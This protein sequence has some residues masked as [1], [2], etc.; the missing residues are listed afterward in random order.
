MDL[1]AIAQL[2][3]AVLHDHLDGGLRPSTIL[4]LADEQGYSGLPEVDESS[5]TA[6]FYQG[7]SGSLETYLEAFEQ[8]V[9]VMQTEAAI[10]RVAYEAGIDLDSQGVVYAEVRYGPMLSTRRGLSLDAVFEAMIDGF[11]RAHRDTGIIV[12]GIATALRHLADSAK[13]AIAAARYVDRGIVAFDLAGP[14]AG[15][16]PDAH[17][18]A[19]RIAR[20]AGL[21]LTLHAGEADGAHSMWRALALCGAQRLGHGVRIVDDAKF[22]NGAL[23]DLGAF[24]QRVRDHQV[25]LEVAVTSNLQ[26]GPWALPT[27]HPFGAMFGAGFNVSINTDNRLMSGTTMNDEYA[28]VAE[29][30][31][32]S[33]A[34]L[35][36]ITVNALRAGFG[37]WPERRRLI[38]RI[39]P[40]RDG[41]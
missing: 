20:D 28:L 23:T 36:A 17:L 12:Y 2:P 4:E 18:E 41:W 19:C 26:T 11:A 9:S 35:N 33:G 27:D 30:F 5:L 6:W 13:V 16:P 10:S 24:A 29:A 38:D 15:F 14:E 21:G 25:P 22:A 32:L 7:E 40:T 8:T 34:D 37:D 39:S 31:D 1:N 3:K